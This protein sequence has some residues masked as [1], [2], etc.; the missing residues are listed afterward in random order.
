MIPVAPARHPGASR[1]TIQS[2]CATAMHQRLAMCNAARRSDT[3]IV[4][5]GGW[6]GEILRSASD[7]SGIAVQ[8]LRFR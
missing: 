4:G 8:A 6:E 1:P 2:G 5:L 7:R 3:F